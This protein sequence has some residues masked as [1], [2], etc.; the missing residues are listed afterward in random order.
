[1]QDNPR[2]IA[3]NYGKSVVNQN[4]GDKLGRLIFTRPVREIQV[5]P[6]SNL[7]AMQIKCIKNKLI[8]IRC[9]LTAKDQKSTMVGHGK[10]MMIASNQKKFGDD[11][12]T[13]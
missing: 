11:L 3:N 5:I 10:T 6:Q 8:Y 7:V 9:G 2:F 1:M 4:P 13:K 12:R